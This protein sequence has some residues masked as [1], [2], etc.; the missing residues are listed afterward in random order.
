MQIGG[1][2]VV[3]VGLVVVFAICIPIPT[4]GRTGKRMGMQIGGVSVVGGIVVVVVVVVVAAVIA[5][6]GLR[7]V[8]NQLQQDRCVPLELVVVVEL[9]GVVVEVV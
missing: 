1:V 7:Q 6:I 4:S 2:G 5:V 8:H 3:V 9:D